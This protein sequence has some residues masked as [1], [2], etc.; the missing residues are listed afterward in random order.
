M[1]C[2]N[3]LSTNVPLPELGLGTYEGFEGGLYAGGVN[4]PP[5]EHVNLGLSV[6]ASVEPL[7][8]AGEIDQRGTFDLLS[9]GPSHAQIEAA[10]FAAQRASGLYADLNSRFRLI[11]GAIGGS[12]NG[13]IL[14]RLVDPDHA[15]WTESKAKVSN[16]HS[17]P[18]RIQFAW[19]KTTYKNPASRML[20]LPERIALTADE[21]VVVCRNI[22]LHFPNC[23]AV[24]ISSRSYAGWSDGNT[25]PEPYA[26]EDGFAVREAVDRMVR[27]LIV[28]DSAM[29]WIA[30]GPYWWSPTLLTCP[31]DFKVD[32][33]HPN[34]EGGRRLG[35][36]LYE[37]FKAD[38]VLQGFAL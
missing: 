9:V 24:W 5:L 19:L 26:Y 34:D 7:N 17:S 35:D 27:G 32:F 28:P 29:P 18:G 3:P 8:Y 4:A 10:G 30:W 25:S 37:A 12:P 22:R 2:A 6:C 1:T 33:F 21:L 38:A 20:N 23:K 15:Y 31:A 13:G 16:Q 14:Q 11:N 36:V